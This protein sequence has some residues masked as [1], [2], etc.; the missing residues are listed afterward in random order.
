MN[1]TPLGPDKPRPSTFQ[2]VQPPSNFSAAPQPSPAPWPTPQPTSPTP[3]P[4]PV[5]PPPAPK[6]QPSPIFTPP[7]A[8]PIGTPV[9]TPPAAPMPSTVKPKKKHRKLKILIV[10]LIVLLLVAGAA[11]TYW[12]SRHPTVKIVY[13]AT[14]GNGVP[15]TQNPV[16]GKLVLTPA[17]VPQATTKTQTVNGKV[18]QQL[19]MSDGFSYMVS[20]VV[21]YTSTD[22]TN[23]PSAGKK[24]VAVTIVGGNRSKT[25]NIIFSDTF[26]QVRD[27]AGNML[28]SNFIGDEL[29]NNS[30]STL[31]TLKT[32]E[33]QT[34]IAV[35]EVPNDSSKLTLVYKKQYQNS[36]NKSVFTVE[37]DVPI[38]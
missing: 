35:F 19:N 34:G 28:D 26:F 10:V 12:K 25:G 8:A 7:S 24:F 32:G 23:V 16:N 31:A 4:R 1:E 11:G 13:P 22:P 29:P 14:V 3:S 38:R 5:A 30:F 2:D 9:A 37:G 21:D 17:I 15:D 20:K 36:T 27:S 33:Q 18:G 6:P